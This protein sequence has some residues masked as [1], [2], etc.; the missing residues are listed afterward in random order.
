MSENKAL[1]V[2]G[3][4]GLGD[5]AR[6]ITQ[7]TIDGA[8]AFLSRMCLPAAEEF[9]LLLRDKVSRWRDENAVRML[10]QANDINL[11]HCPDTPDNPTE[12]AN[13]RLVHVAIEEASWIEDE[14][15]RSMWAG[16]LCGASIRVRRQRQ[17]R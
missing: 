11:S 6:I 10:N 9:G 7:G 17:S 15:V 4:K 1:D 13:P 8:R 16:L 12:Q 14:Q 5:S 2:L 3:V